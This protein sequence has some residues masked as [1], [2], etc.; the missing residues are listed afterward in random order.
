MPSKVNL[1][2]TLAL[3]ALVAAGCTGKSAD[4]APD[5]APLRDAK[6]CPAL[7]KA[8]V[9]AERDTITKALDAAKKD[10][11]TVRPDMSVDA[12]LA[13]ELENAV[14]RLGCKPATWVEPFYDTLAEVARE[15]GHDVPSGAWRLVSAPVDNTRFNWHL[16][17]VYLYSMYPAGELT[18]R[19]G[20]SPDFAYHAERHEYVDKAGVTWL[21]WEDGLAK[22]HQPAEFQDAAV[23]PNKKFTAVDAAG[24]SF[25]AVLMPDGATP[26]QPVPPPYRYQ[27]ANWLTTGPL[28][29]TYNYTDSHP[30]H[31]YWQGAEHFVDDMYLHLAGGDV[32]PEPPRERWVDPY[33]D[34][35]TFVQRF[36]RVKWAV[37][38]GG[39]VTRQ[40][41]GSLTVAA[42]GAQPFTVDKDLFALVQEW[43]DATG[44][45]VEG[46]EREDPVAAFNRLQKSKIAACGPKVTEQW[47][48]AVK[49]DTGGEAVLGLANGFHYYTF[50]RMLFESGAWRIAADYDVTIGDSAPLP[51]WLPALR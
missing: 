13:R 30:E 37:A 47:C 50:Y 49:R 16:G 17:R 25:E 27:T 45:K 43:L 18:P 21:L 7:A 20:A 44:Q 23:K 32:Y 38:G 9:T 31:R 4:P 34:W 48:L 39:K 14:K 42:D 29:G 28:I 8:Y 5:P 51:D 3:L 22:Y 1:T 6:D 41:D 40:P 33:G 12:G 19:D 46:A 15:A 36:E 35:R 24:G 10:P 2:A 26:T 11:A